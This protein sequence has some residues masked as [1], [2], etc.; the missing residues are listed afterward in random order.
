MSSLVHAISATR[1]LTQQ[2]VTVIG[3][4]AVVC[5]LSAAHRATTDLDIVDRHND[6]QQPRLQL[7]VDGTGRPSGP[8]GA[9]VPT[10]M[11]VVQVDVLEVSD[12]DLDR[13]PEDP[14]GRLY[15]LAHAWAADAATP[16]IIRAHR[17]AEV[18]V[19]AAEPGPL[20]AMKLQSTI[21]RGAAKEGTDLL[22]IVRLGLDR[23][24]GPI[25]RSQLSQADEQ[26]K[27]AIRWHVD[28]CFRQH[29]RRSLSLIR[30]IPEGADIDIDDLSLV[31]EL[32]MQTLTT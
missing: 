17:S 22:D 10:A 5:R 21:D 32:L 29:A 26:L 25:A 1:E 7:L 27:T 20:I 23:H 6:T 14:T 9:L 2:E 3:G 28:W 24:A 16:V 4:L 15:V 18:H 13:L 8:S 11:G 19:L 31:R 12:S 30:R